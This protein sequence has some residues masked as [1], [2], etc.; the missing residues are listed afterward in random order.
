ME[1]KIVLP[2]KENTSDNIRNVRWRYSQK[3]EN[4]VQ[5]IEF[6]KQDGKFVVVSDRDPALLIEAPYIKEL[7]TDED[8]SAWLQ[9]LQPSPQLD[10]EELLAR[11]ADQ[12]ADK[13]V[14]EVKGDIY[15][16]YENSKGGYKNF[17]LISGKD[18]RKQIQV[19]AA[20]YKLPS[21]SQA[22]LDTVKENMKA[23]VK[24]TLSLW[25]DH[26]Q[27]NATEIYVETGKSDYLLSIENEKQ[28]YNVAGKPK[29]PSF[30]A[31][32][33]RHQK[34]EKFHLLLIS[35]ENSAGKEDFLHEIDRT[36]FEIKFWKLPSFS[37]EDILNALSQCGRA[38]NAD[39]IAI[40]RGGGDE[41]LLAAFNRASVAKAV[42]NCAIPIMLGIGHTKDNDTLCNQAAAGYA[43]TPNHAAQTLN[44]LAAEA[45]QKESDK[46]LLG[47][48]RKLIRAIAKLL[49]A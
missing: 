33:L 10:V 48:L 2:Q 18:G 37:E 6:Q 40:V 22:Q 3:N 23:T 9:A 8:F 17:R 31:N 39:I 5:G 28:E 32:P 1:S 34:G 47:L 26:L 45:K 12:F 20:R 46:G 29:Q 42:A 44:R 16:I 14:Y 43:D 24:G 25:N 30:T 4:K 35:T 21:E 19:F 13:T 36:N 27:L 41:R 7:L 38:G 11:A 49:G 15:D